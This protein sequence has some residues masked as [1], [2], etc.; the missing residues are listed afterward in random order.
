MTALKTTFSFS[1]RPNIW[2]SQKDH[3]G[4]WSVLLIRK[5]DSS[6]SRKYDLN[7]WTENE[8]WSFSK[9]YM[10]M[11]Y[12]YQMFWKDGLF[13]KIA[14]EYDLSC[15][16]WKDGFFPWKHIFSLD[17]KLKMIGL[18]E[19][20][21]TWYFL[22]ICVG[23]REVVLRPSA[24]NIQRQSSPVKMHLKVIETLDWHSRKTSNNSPYLYG[25][26]YRRFGKLIFS[27]KTQE[28]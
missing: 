16:I 27:E 3:A 19:Y 28:T 20:M 12:L 21:E 26:L 24:K 23:V 13:K 14:L 22:C 4:I 18:K 6:F 25:G 15:I 10:E 5:N 2:S 11:W 8:R 9:K 17:G 1:K 7:S